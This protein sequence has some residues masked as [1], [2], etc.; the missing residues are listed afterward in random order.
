MSFVNIFHMQNC[1]LITVLFLAVLLKYAREIN[2]YFCFLK[3]NVIIILLTRDNKIF[4]N[5]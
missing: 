3:K 1:R 2:F 4:I 5:N